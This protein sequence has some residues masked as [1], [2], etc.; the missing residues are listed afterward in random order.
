VNGQEKAEC[1]YCQKKLGGSS[2]NGT[3]HLLDH[4]QRCPRRTI[5]D[6]RQSILVKE[7]KKVDGS[8]SYLSN[9]TFSPENSRKD[10]A[11]MIIVHEYPLT[12]VEHHGFRK[13]VG[14]LQ[15][16]FKVPCRNTVKSDI[17]KIYDFERLK[18][19]KLLGRNTS[20]VAITTDMWTANH[21]RKGFMA[22]TA[23]FI[24]EFWNLQS[25]IMRYSLNV[26]FTHILTHKVSL[27]VFFTL[28]STGLFMCLHHIQLMLLQRFFMI[29]YV[30]GI[31][32]ENCLL[33]PLIIAPQT[34]QLLTSY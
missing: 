2:K 12:M 15:P 25:R 24:D 21:Q 22:I 18:T 14:G 34:M 10:L 28:L 17:L 13:F 16:L 27:N 32:I 23:H 11:E 8:S 1:N 29:L 30:I 6:I 20:R 9:Y 19:R 31:S 5:R 7:Q 3:K 4:F 26:F 33:L